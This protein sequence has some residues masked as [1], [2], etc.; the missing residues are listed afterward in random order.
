MRL[1]KCDGNTYDIGGAESMADHQFVR[2]LIG[3]ADAGEPLRKQDMQRL[4][5]MALLVRPLA[6]Y[7]KELQSTPA[8]ALV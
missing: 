4:V 8:E 5:N 2:N 1:V 3:R 6:M 7:I